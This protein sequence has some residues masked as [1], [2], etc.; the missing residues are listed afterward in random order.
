LELKIKKPIR[1]KKIKN[2]YVVK[3]DVYHYNNNVD[4]SITTYGL[5]ATEE[6]IARMKE[7]ILLLEILKATETGY[8]NYVR[9]LH[10]S[11]DSLYDSF[12]IDY[13]MNNKINKNFDFTN[14]WESDFVNDHL[15]GYNVFFYDENGIQNKVEV[16]LSKE[17]KEI[18]KNKAYKKPNDV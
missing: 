12:N 15:E 1:A 3:V 14:C 8:Y 18:I 9:P 13:E 11:E 4:S 10:E 16:K 7:I 17:D 6:E 5:F 2:G